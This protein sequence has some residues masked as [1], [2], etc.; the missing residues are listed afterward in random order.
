M[1]NQT[2]QMERLTENRKKAIIELARRGEAGEK[3]NARQLCKQYG[4]SWDKHGT[5]LHPTEETTLDAGYKWQRCHY[6]IM[7]EHYRMEIYGMGIKIAENLALRTI[8]GITGDNAVY[9]HKVY[10]QTL[11]YWGTQEQREKIGK[12]LRWELEKIMNGLEMIYK[13]TCDKHNLSIKLDSIDD[14]R[15]A[16]GPDGDDYILIRSLWTDPRFQ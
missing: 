4:I 13:V 10:S 9:T 16:K 5:Y 1:K 14:V 6:A 11:Y 3:E 7:I 8:R 12:I 15:P 2:S